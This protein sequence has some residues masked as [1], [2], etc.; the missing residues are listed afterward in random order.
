M[1][2]RGRSIVNDLKGF[3]KEH[4]V[5]LKKGEVVRATVKANKSD[6]PQCMQKK[7]MDVQLLETI[8]RKINYA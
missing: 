8:E 4:I 5:P 1:L 3:L 7:R 2:G 6:C